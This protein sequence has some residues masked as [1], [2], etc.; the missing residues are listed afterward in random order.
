MDVRFRESREDDRLSPRLAVSGPAS[1]EC[2]TRPP[3]ELEDDD[4]VWLMKDDAQI[5]GLV[6]RLVSRRARTWSRSGS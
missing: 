6:E 2:T 5:A 1:R 3:L 4:P